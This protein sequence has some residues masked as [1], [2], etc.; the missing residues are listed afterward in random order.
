MSLFGNKKLYARIEDN[1]WMIV[2]REGRFEGENV[3]QSWT[4]FITFFGTSTGNGGMLPSTIACN[5]HLVCIGWPAILITWLISALD[6]KLSLLYSQ[7]K[8]IE[9]EINIK[10]EKNTKKNVEKKLQKMLKKLKK[11]Y[12][13]WKNI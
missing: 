5:Y 13:K 8:K 1:W 11:C 12:K 2:C 9:N 7:K 4:N 6:F 3:Q 10:I